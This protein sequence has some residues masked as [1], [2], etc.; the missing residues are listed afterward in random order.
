MPRHRILH[1]LERQRTVLHGADE[2]LEGGHLLLLRRATHQHGVASGPNGRDCG[3][4]DPILAADRLHLE[5]VAEDQP[6]VSHLLF[7]DRVDDEW[8]QR[9]GTLLVVRGNQD[10]RRHDRRHI[11]LDRRTERHELHRI[12]S[13]WRVLDERELVM[14]IC[15]GVAVSREMLAAGGYPFPLQRGDDDPAKPR[16]IFSPFGQG[17][18]ADHRVAGIRMD[19]EDWC[20]VQRDPYRLQLGRQRLRKSLGQA[21]VSAAPERDHRRP[22]RERRTQPRDTPALLV[23]AHPQRQL[24][25]QRLRFTRDICDLV[26]R[27]D[28]PREQNNPAEVELSCEGFEI[29]GERMTRKSSNR[30]LTN[31]TT[32]VLQRHTKIIAG[33]LFLTA[34][35]TAGRCTSAHTVSGVATN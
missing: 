13:I 8:R 26:G 3:F 5:V 9:G 6:P 2:R 16:D 25:S 19:V 14:R 4:R 18:I 28:V 7:Q 32:N 21:L 31:M 24:S 29:G 22:Q 20:V 1:T 35:D 23:H 15:R 11:G 27:F 30:E 17:A 12:E 34:A 10:V 33:S